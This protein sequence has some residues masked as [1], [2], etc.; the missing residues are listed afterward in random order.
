[1]LERVTVTADQG[2]EKSAIWAPTI[3]KKK[4]RQGII[5]DDLRSVLRDSP[6]TSQWNIY[7]R[8]GRHQCRKRILL[9]LSCRIYYQ[10]AKQQVMVFV[11]S[12]LQYCHGRA[13][14]VRDSQVAVKCTERQGV[15][16]V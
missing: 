14:R 2:L 3:Q 11:L 10:E 13:R 4:S 16:S 12:R 7:K 9:W 6:S 8:H 5:G 1:M 15:Q